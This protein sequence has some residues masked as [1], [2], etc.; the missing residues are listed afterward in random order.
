MASGIVLD[1]DQ[2]QEYLE[3]QLKQEMIKNGEVPNS[4]SNISRR[5]IKEVYIPPDEIEE[6]H[7][8]YSKVVV[9]DFEDDY[10]IS[11]EEREAM[12]KRYEKFFRLKRNYTKKILANI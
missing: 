4:I 9:Q 2:N 11:R 1:A 6:L 3:D 7:D 8:R 10:H 5:K 12:R